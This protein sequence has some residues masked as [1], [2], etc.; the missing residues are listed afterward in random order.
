MRMYMSKVF[1]HVDL[2]LTDNN[3]MLFLENP[4]NKLKIR[5][6]YEKYLT[7]D[8]ELFHLLTHFQVH[9]RSGGYNAYVQSFAVFYSQWEI[10]NSKFQS[11]TKRFVKVENSSDIAQL[12]LKV[13]HKEEDKKWGIKIVEFDVSKTKSIERWFKLKN[14]PVYPLLWVQIKQK[15]VNS[16]FTYKLKQKIAARFISLK[17]LKSCN[18]NA[19]SNIDVYNLGLKGIPL[20]FT[21]I[22][23][24]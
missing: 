24:V 12:K 17:L 13:K 1:N 20:D 3:P 21:P 5:I 10:E 2:P 8:K 15:Y 18:A 6:P 19:N 22:S 16:T 11:M 14:P 4:K 7:S 9:L 23:F